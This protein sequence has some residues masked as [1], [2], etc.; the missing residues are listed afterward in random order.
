[1][2]MCGLGVMVFLVLVSHTIPTTN[3]VLD[4]M[5]SLVSGIHILLLMVLFPVQ[6]LSLLG[7]LHVYDV[8]NDMLFLALMV[9]YSREHFSA[10]VT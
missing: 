8:D 7:F 3:D 5:F 2:L 6:C 9:L 4:Y 1:M 10:E